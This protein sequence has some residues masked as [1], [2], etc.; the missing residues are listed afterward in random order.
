[1]EPLL[2]AGK[3]TDL[4]CHARA[5]GALHTAYALG[6]TGVVPDVDV[7]R[8]NLAVIPLVEGATLVQLDPQQGHP[9]EHAEDRAQ[10]AD[11]TAERPLDGDC[12]RDQCGGERQLEVEQR[13]D[14]GEDLGGLPGQF[15]LEDPSQDIGDSSLERSG[16]A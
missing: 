4:M 9:V 3:S 16:R 2:I 11:E 13:A 10:R 1:M 12:C 7:H 8:A 6:R 5:F 14:H 15:Q